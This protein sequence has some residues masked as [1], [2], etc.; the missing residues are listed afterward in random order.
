MN[1]I[2]A[3]FGMSPDGG[4]GALELA[5]CIALCAV[6]GAVTAIRVLRVRTRR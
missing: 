1:F 4:S 2:E 3:A 5:W 6:I